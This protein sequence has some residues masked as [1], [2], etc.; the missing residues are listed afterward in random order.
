MCI[1]LWKWAALI[2]LNDIQTD[3]LTELINIAFGLTAAKLSEISGHRIRLNPPTLSVRPWSIQGRELKSFVVGPITSIQ[4]VFTG[5]ISG[6]AILLLN[7]GDAARLS[8][9]LVHEDVRSL[10]LGCSAND[11]LLETGNMVLGS[12]LGL[13]GNLLDARFTFW[14]PRLDLDS[15]EHILSSMPVVGNEPQCAI[16]MTSSF[17]I[18]D[19]EVDGRLLMVLGMSSLKRLIHAVARWEGSEAA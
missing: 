2:K 6:H 19:Q 12:C 7:C 9:L 8:Q 13:I 1:S 11:I 17:A 4:Q 15:I 16:V 18:M 10:N 5:I 14:P 3:S